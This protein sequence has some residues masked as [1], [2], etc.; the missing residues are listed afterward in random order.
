MNTEGLEG[1]KELL[2][3]NEFL[4][5]SM[6]Q[7]GWGQGRTLV[8]PPDQRSVRRRSRKDGWTRMDDVTRHYCD[9]NTTRLPH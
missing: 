3:A 6:K 4:E 7:S 2:K 9:R 8:L 1:V 5:S